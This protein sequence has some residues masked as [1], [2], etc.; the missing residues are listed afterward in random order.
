MNTDQLIA[1]LA[2][3]ARAAPPDGLRAVRRALLGGALFAV[4]GTLVVVGPL[5]APVFATFLPW[6]KLLPTA[7][8][9][10][11]AWWWLQRC[12]R[13]VSRVAPVRRR[14]L[15]CWAL[16]GALGLGSLLLLPQGARMP[17]LMGHTWWICPCMLSVL[18]MPIL[19]LML[20]AARGLPVAQPRQAGAAIG[21]VA[22]AMAAF[23]YSLACSEPSPAFVAAW[24]SSGLLLSTGAGALLGPRWLQW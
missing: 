23:A 20:R 19:L 21:L 12:S 10:V 11:L 16:L 24:Y 9:L 5:P 3:G 15:G 17:A 6:M 14:V 1:Q 4:V 18:S 13:P 7:L 22:G 2:Q 8:L